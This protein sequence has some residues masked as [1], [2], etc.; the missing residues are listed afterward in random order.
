MLHGLM[1]AFLAGLAPVDPHRGSAACSRTYC[2]FKSL[3][4]VGELEKLK[5]ISLVPNASEGAS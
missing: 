4:R 1:S 2:E 3:C 5:E